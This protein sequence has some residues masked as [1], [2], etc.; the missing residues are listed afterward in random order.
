MAP[1]ILITGASG[2]LGGDM[3]EEMKRASMLSHGTIYAL[4]RTEEQAKQVKERYGATP[5][6][7]DLSDQSK[8]TSEFVDKEISIVFYLIHAAIADTQLLFINALET[9]GQKLHVQTHFLHTT[10]AKA[11]SSFT[12]HPTDRPLSDADP[13]LFEI[14]KNA[15]SD[16]AMMKGV[17]LPTLSQS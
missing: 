5:M 13:Q 1:N 2:Y 6:S 14:Q 15:Q 7:L 3:L 4:V 11:F 16:F 9:V 8:I 10:G 12:G 17:S